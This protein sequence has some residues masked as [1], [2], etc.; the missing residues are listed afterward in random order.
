M[1][2][3]TYPCT[4]EGDP[5]HPGVC[6]PGPAVHTATPPSPCGMIP[7]QISVLTAAGAR[8]EPAFPG[9]RG[10]R[11]SSWHL[12][13]LPCAAQG[14][15]TA[16]LARPPR[17]TP[18][19]SSARKMSYTHT[20]D[21]S[22]RTCGR[23]CWARGPSSRSTP[24]TPALPP[25]TVKGTGTATR[26]QRTTSYSGSFSPSRQRATTTPQPAMTGAVPR[27]VDAV[28]EATRPTPAMSRLLGSIT[29]P[30]ESEK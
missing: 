25:H 17:A 8:P 24:S 21:P 13:Q 14:R 1:T 5:S 18:F 4:A 11:C 26:V 20:P 6:V 23:R 15:S 29:S 3:Q 22:A 2:S 12:S 9:R 28:R 7:S 30:S 27:P 19:S 16:W 10:G